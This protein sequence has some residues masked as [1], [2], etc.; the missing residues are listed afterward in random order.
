MKKRI[1]LSFAAVLLWWNAGIAQNQSLLWYEAP[2]RNWNE[3]LPIGNGR[4]GGMIHGGIVKEVIQLNEESLVAG[5]HFD[6]NNPLAAG[7]GN[8]TSS[9]IEQARRKLHRQ[10]W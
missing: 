4:L 6:N 1:F 7:R 3:S 8:R 10:V 2:A 9:Y 5:H